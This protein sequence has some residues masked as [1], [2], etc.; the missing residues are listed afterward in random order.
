MTR[1]RRAEIVQDCLGDILERIEDTGWDL[2]H[3]ASF[4]RRMAHE[5]FKAAD[6]L[7]GRPPKERRQGKD[8]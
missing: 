8:H 5:C 3:K 4:L 6:V 1:P 7:E 2:W